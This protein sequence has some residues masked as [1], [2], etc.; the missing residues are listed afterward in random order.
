MLNKM[1]ESAGSWMIKVLL[2]IIV[3]AFVLVGTGSYK[4]NKNSR[5]AEV[6]GEKISMAEFQQTYNA[7]LQ[8][9]RMQFG[10]KLN[11]DMLK[12][13]NIR[14]QAVDRL[15]DSALLRQAARENDLSV[16]KKELVDSITHIDVFKQNGAFSNQRYEMV[17]AQNKLNPETFE[18]GQREQM[19]INKLQSVVTSGAKVSEDE[20]HQWYNWQNGE[21]NFEYVKFAPD[22]VEAPAVSDQEAREYF[23]AHQEEYKTEPMKKARYL[24]FDPK[25]YEDKVEVTDAE[26]AEFYNNN[27][28][29][30]QQPETVSARH[31]LIKVD[32]KATPEVVAEKKQEIEKILEKAKAGEDFAELAKQYSEDPSK[33]NGGDL[34]SFKREDMVKPFADKAFSMEVGQISEPV[35]TRYGWHLIKKEGEQAAGIKPLEAVKDGIRRKLVEQAAKSKAYDEALA[36]YD[37]SFTGE[38]LADNAAERGLNMVTTDFFTLRSGPKNMPAG[39]E[40]AQTVFELP[41]MEVSDVVEIGGSYYLIQVMDE[42]DARIPEFETVKDAVTKAAV[43]QKRR[44]MAKEAA[45]KFLAD[46]KTAGSLSKAAAADGKEVKESGFVRRGAAIPNIGNDSTLSGAAFDLSR[47]KPFSDKVVEGDTGLYVIA[48]KERKTPEDEQFNKEKDA[49]INQLLSQKKSQ[50]FES[51]IAYLRGKS[52]ISISKQLVD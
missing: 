37:A 21:L 28:D 39:A 18:A 23:K 7:I 4:A 48:Y 5:A 1:R 41:K 47:D 24:R 40:F 35:K 16:S 33:A 25:A 46:A 44:E 29:N 14:K 17:L 50:L 15:V 19:L 10:N 6:N 38:E 45:A 30:Y 8:N 42:Q 43:A 11:D 26:I 2:G 34:G 9:L 27:M 52:D 13:F 49:V 31:I 51:Y 32:P 20:A 22:S 3:L 12:M 36:L